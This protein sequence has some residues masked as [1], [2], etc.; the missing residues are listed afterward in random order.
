MS[1]SPVENSIEILSEF[2]N[3]LESA[4]EPDGRFSG[5]NLIKRISQI[6]LK[7]SRVI[8][9]LVGLMRACASEQQQASTATQIEEI[10]AT[11]VTLSELLIK[12]SENPQIN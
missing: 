12:L 10:T 6:I 4:D 5:I 7:T 3:Q 11:L 8:S 1:N 9:Y 2:L